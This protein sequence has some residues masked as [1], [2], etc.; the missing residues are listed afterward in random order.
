MF[1]AM[2]DSADQHIGQFRDYLKQSG[3]LDNTVF[4]VMSDNGADPVELNTLNLPFRLWY[5]VNY[6]L[7]IE[8]LGQKGSYVHYGQDW[9]EVSTR[10]SRVSR[11]PPLKGACG[12][13]S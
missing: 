9:A 10:L 13:L 4:V 7:G 6:A 2:L 1:A 8:K 5:R 3:Q 11:A 12:C